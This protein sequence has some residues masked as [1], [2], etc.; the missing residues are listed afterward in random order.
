[1]DAEEAS[2]KVEEVV[3][4]VVVNDAMTRVGRTKKSRK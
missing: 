3:D 4:E 2:V 1:M